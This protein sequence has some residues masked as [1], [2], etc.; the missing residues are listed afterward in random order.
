M[1]KLLKL[2]SKKAKRFKKER[3]LDQEANK[4]ISY[5]SLFLCIITIILSVVLFFCECDFEKEKVTAFY[6]NGVKYGENICIGV[7]ASSLLAVIVS[8]VNYL[9]T[10]KETLENFFDSVMRIANRINVY[11]FDGDLEYKNNYLIETY[12]SDFSE[13]DQLYTRI[14]LVLKVKDRNYVYETLYH[15][16][17]LRRQIIGRYNQELVKYQNRK[18]GDIKPVIEEIEQ[19][20]LPLEVHDG[21]EI[22]LGI[23]KKTIAYCWIKELTGKYY[24]IMYSKPLKDDMEYYIDDN[25]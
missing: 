25:E 14:A 6:C 8:R 18:E 1:K 22:I 24:E 10:R 9:S 16:I 2:I 23:S 13:L 11:D 5:I 21:D 19:S 17:D 20:F 7:F 15:P 4:M 3:I 12:R